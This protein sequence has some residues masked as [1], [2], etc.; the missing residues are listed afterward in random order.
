MPVGCLIHILNQA[1]AISLSLAKVKM[2]NFT[3]SEA[4][5]VT[6]GVI[7]LFPIALASARQAGVV[8]RVAAGVVTVPWFLVM[9]LP[10]ALAAT[11]AS[12]GVG[13]TAIVSKGITK[14]IIGQH[15]AEPAVD[16]N[17]EQPEIVAKPKN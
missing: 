9:C 15:K 11:V 6:F 13:W 16:A 17:A 12:G 2:G 1:H 14:T 10:G 5:A 7:S 4:G 3:A 8:V